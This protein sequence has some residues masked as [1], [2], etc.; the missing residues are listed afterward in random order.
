MDLEIPA[1]TTS[2]VY[3]PADNTDDILEGGK[4]LSLVKEIQVIGTEEGYVILKLGSG[5]YMFTK[6]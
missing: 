1:N 2:T 6:K 5:K 4:V 3:V